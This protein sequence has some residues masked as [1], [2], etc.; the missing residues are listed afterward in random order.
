VKRE[1]K[2]ALGRKKVRKRSAIAKAAGPEKGKKKKRISAD[3]SAEKTR[4]KTLQ[5]ET[6]HNGEK[7][8]WSIVL[9]KSH[10]NC[11]TEGTKM[12]PLVKTL[13]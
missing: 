7:K 6:R 8:F 4:E 1:Q 3:E 13:S 10:R 11:G 9:S 2:K 12:C 5:G